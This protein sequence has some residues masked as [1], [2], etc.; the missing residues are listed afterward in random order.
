[1]RNDAYW[2]GLALKEAHKAKKKAEVPIGAVVIHEGRVIARAHNLRETTQDPFGHAEFRALEKASK[3]LGRWRLEN[4]S[5]YVT[6]EPCVMCAGACV[7]SRVS[8]VFYGAHDPKAGA[9]HSLY[10]ILSDTR[11]NHRPQL[12]S[13][14][15]ADECSQLLTTFFKELRIEK[16][17]KNNN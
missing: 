4:C 14:L 3:K 12:K 16:K 15:L 17:T 1:M 9:A 7:L 11:L 13:G 6:L 2:M 10:H 5:L 8:K